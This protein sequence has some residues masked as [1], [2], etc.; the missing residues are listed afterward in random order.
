MPWDGCDPSSCPSDC[1]SRQVFGLDF[2]THGDSPQP[3]GSISAPERFHR[4]AWGPKFLDSGTQQV[5][6][7]GSTENISYMLAF[8][9]VQG[10]WGPYTI[11]PT[12]WP[13]STSTNYLA[14]WYHCWRACRWISL[15]LGSIHHH[16]Q[17]SQSRE[18]ERFA[19]Q[20]AE[21]HW[22]RE[23]G[24]LNV[25]YYFQQAHQL[26]YVTSDNGMGRR[27]ARSVCHIAAHLAM[28][29]R[30]PDPS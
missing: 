29:L 27:G 7:L 18:Q 22:G 15:P 21:A 8:H 12:T 2:A 23:C 14:D 24:F 16:G 20:D 4:L 28:H 9:A 26:H 3:L 30:Q 17:D 11:S 1:F 25:L 19:C 10:L 5:R 6:S 13:V